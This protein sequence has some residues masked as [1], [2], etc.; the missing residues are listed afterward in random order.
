[1]HTPPPVTLAVSP[2]LEFS[3]L[4]ATVKYESAMRLSIIL[5]PGGAVGDVQLYSL[6]GHGHALQHPLPLLITA[7]SWQ[8][9][10]HHGQTPQR[11]FVLT[12]GRREKR[13]AI[14]CLV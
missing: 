10:Q 8:L 7:P 3:E 1:M 5:T 13:D 12:L 4:I 11:Y 14:A 2:T 6:P 9:P